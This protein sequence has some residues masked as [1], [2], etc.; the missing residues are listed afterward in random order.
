M[1]PAGTPPVRQ[2]AMDTTQ[3]AGR[4]GGGPWGRKHA[5]LFLLLPYLLSV[6][7]RIFLSLPLEAPMVVDELG[8]LGNAR[9]LATGAGLVEPAGRAAYKLGYS[10]FLVPVFLIESDPGA[11]YRLALVVNALL[12]STVYPVIFVFLGQLRPRLTLPQRALAA[13]AVG[14]YPPAVLYPLSAMSDSALMPAY[15]GYAL[16]LFAAVEKPRWWKWAAVGALAALLYAIHERTVGIL[17]LTAA[18]ALVLPAFRGWRSPAPWCALPAAAAVAAGVRLL[19]PRGAS[20][21]RTRSG[22]VLDRAFAD[23]GAPIVE[24]LGQGVYL[25]LSSL[26]LPLLAL[27]LALVLGLRR[28]PLLAGGRP[29]W[30]LLLGGGLSAFAISTLFMASA[31]QSNLTYLL[32]GR[33]NEGVLL[34][35]LAVAL[36]LCHGLS[37]GPAQ[38]WSLAAAAAA[39][40]VVGATAAG[41]VAATR[42][43]LFQQAPYYFNVLATF[44]LVDLGLGS[45][46]KLAWV[47]ALL[48]AAV[49]LSFAVRWEVGVW[50]VLIVF[51]AAA[52]HVYQGFWKPFSGAKARQ[53]ELARVVR[54]LPE[55]P[56]R[57]LYDRRAF[58]S[59]HYYN[60]SYFLPGIALPRVDSGP[61]LPAEPTADLL[62]SS[63]PDPAQA[64]P[65]ARLVAMENVPSD[66]G[67][68]FQYLWVLP[69][70][71][72]SRLADR[73]W[74]F[75]AEFPD[76]VLCSA[77]RS[78]LE[79][80]SRE[81]PAGVW[82]RERIRL[83]IENRGPCPWPNADG[84]KRGLDSVRVGILWRPAD[85][86]AGAVAEDRVELPRTL[87]PG[88]S[89]EVD[90]PLAPPSRRSG[91]LPR[92][93]WTVEIGLLQEGHAWFAS[94]GDERL[95]LAAVN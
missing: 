25:A 15:C 18:G 32:Y 35:F 82:T 11:A 69:G 12:I 21:P 74:L 71:L 9:F 60:Y 90:V 67:R 38:R 92:Q 63:R 47:L 20:Y 58:P 91:L 50:L 41:L 6:A 17:L 87:L 86:P 37:E 2:V 84:L 64:L 10:L 49:A 55:R 28:E 23:L 39:A 3:E 78:A 26:G 24:A 8:Y 54:E 59:F 89:V 44:P 80:V 52:L 81:P 19:S 68:Y 72:Q 34:P 46:G 13:A 16:A 95:R 27:A 1:R 43:D 93:R 77:P 40:S 73:G 42:S 36:A 57:L 70:E 56:E 61:E 30:L 94:W 65:G 45:P 31:G 83:R 51:G 5:V 85:A 75:P 48:F 88:Q 66:F 33:Y 53:H 4:I 22:E 62:I 7:L 29:F 14:L 79:V 76:R